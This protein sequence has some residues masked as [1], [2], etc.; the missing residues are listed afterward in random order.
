MVAKIKKYVLMIIAAIMIQSLTFIL[1]TFNP[2]FKVLKEIEQKVEAKIVN[3]LT[4]IDFYPPVFDST[5][6]LTFIESIKSCVNYLNFKI[7]PN[8]RIPF[9]LIAAQASLESNFG[10]SRFSIEANNILG[11]RT[12]DKDDRQVKSKSNPNADWGLKVFN[13]KCGC[14]YYFIN[15][16]NSH[17]AYEEFRELRIKQ[18]K[19]GFI[20]PKKLAET[21]TSYASDKNYIAKVKKQIDYIVEIL[22]KT[23]G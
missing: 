7:P 17:Y 16:L 5:S 8:E 22:T 12:Y 2:N 10:T 13:T 4:S 1:G 14:V 23:T 19:D 6:E 9:E 21:L 20:Q 18:N 3:Q 15:L 11:I